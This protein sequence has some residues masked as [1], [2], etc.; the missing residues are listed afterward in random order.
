[1]GA[2]AMA[3]YDD[4]NEFAYAIGIIGGN[5]PGGDEVTP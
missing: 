1:M 5:N 2:V 4:G 3:A